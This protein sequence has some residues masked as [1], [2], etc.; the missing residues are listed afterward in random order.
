MLARERPNSRPLPSELDDPARHAR[1]AG[2]AWVLKHARRS[3]ASSSSR[4]RRRPAGCSARWHRGLAGGAYSASR[5]CTSR[6]T[7]TKC[8]YDSAA[9]TRSPSATRP[10]SANEAPA[11]SVTRVPRC[12][13]ARRSSHSRARK[14][15]SKRAL[16]QTLNPRRTPRLSLKSR[17]TF[18][19]HLRAR[20]LGPI[21]GQVTGRA[22]DHGALPLERGKSA[23]NRRKRA[24][25]SWAEGGSARP[26]A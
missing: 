1:D 9:C 24:T 19:R 17:G 20:A 15:N 26:N 21:A 10:P 7:N 18:C 2:R 12:C 23:Y 14:K 16:V 8:V 6:G 22:A 13:R 5:P 11:Q 25:P 4:C 3:N